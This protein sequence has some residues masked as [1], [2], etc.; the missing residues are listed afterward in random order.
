MKRSE[1][2]GM[3]D[4]RLLINHPVYVD[5]VTI[6]PLLSI[7]PANIYLYTDDFE[8]PLVRT[9]QNIFEERVICKPIT[10]FTEMKNGFQCSLST[11]KDKSS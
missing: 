8:Q 7:A 10:A 3:I 5:S 2:I 6:A 11:K 9:I 4:R 1:L